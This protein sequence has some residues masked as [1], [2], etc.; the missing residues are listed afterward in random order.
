MPTIS[1]SIVFQ[2]FRMGGYLVSAYWRD[3]ASTV[4]AAP[5]DKPEEAYAATFFPSAKTDSLA[6]VVEVTAGQEL[7]GID[8]RMRK[9]QV[10]RI[11]G[12]VLSTGD[13]QPAGLVLLRPIPRDQTFYL[14]Y[15]QGFRNRKSE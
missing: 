4:A 14:G 10:F 6:Q 9:S 11:R 1:A 8:I 2:I 15:Y 3:Y 5:P 13:G 12:K 7:P